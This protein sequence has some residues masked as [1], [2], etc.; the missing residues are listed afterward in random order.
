M[1]NELEA[2]AKEVSETMNESIQLLASQKQ[3]IASQKQKIA[4]LEAE[5]AM[6]KQAAIKTASTLDVEDTLVSDIVTKL[7][8]VNILNSEFNDSNFTNLKQQ[9]KL[10]YILLNKV[11]SALEDNVLMSQG[12]PVASTST[13]TAAYN[14]NA[15]SNVPAAVL[16]DIA[17]LEAAFNST[18]NF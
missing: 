15:H 16:A 11:A 8:N 9:P 7:A 2:F 18:G 4:S 6:L 1:N 10:A 17:K 13:K 3:K 14:N 12:S 5:N